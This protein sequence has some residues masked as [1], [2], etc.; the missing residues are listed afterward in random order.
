VSG[1]EL[2]DGAENHGELGSRRAVVNRWREVS[3]DGEGKREG[4]D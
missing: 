4:T 2:N 1:W 3:G